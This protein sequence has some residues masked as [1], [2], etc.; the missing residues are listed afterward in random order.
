MRK[1]L[2]RPWT[3]EDDERIRKFV[4]ESVSI[5][6]AAAVFN[7][8]RGSVYD[9]ARKNG[10]PFPLLAETI[11]KAKAVAATPSNNWSTHRRPSRLREE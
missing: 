11:K 9:R 1:L 10:C 5:N 2:F 7:R 3:L 4:A 8:S 6:R